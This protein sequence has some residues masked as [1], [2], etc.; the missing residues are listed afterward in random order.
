MKLLIP[1]TVINT[2]SSGRG[3][4]LAKQPNLEPSSSSKRTTK[5]TLKALSKAVPKQ[6]VNQS[7][8]KTLAS[9]L[10]TESILESAKRPIEIISSL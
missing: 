3:H 6:V 1:I 4:K 7:K 9:D 2:R 10:K 8:K 5:A